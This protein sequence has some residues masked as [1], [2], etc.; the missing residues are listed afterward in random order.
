MMSIKKSIMVGGKR[1]TAIAKALITEGNGKVLVNKIPYE[2]LDF[3]KKL[4]IQEPI[5]IT[6]R[7]LGNFNF[8]IAVNIKGG[9]TEA[10]TEVSRLAIARALVKFTNSEELKRAFARYDKNLL[11]ADTRRK[12][13]YKPGDSKARRKRQ[14]SFR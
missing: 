1:K 8:D 9:G 12:E 6:K 11:V 5:E 13:A 3:F 2:N 4:I 7:V 14:K 10:Q